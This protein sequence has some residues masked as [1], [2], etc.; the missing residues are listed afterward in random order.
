[1]DKD[2]KKILKTISRASFPNLLLGDAV[3]SFREEQENGQE[4][5]RRENKNSNLESLGTTASF[6]G[7]VAGAVLAASTVYNYEKVSEPIIDSVNDNHSIVT[8]TYRKKD[9]M[10][11]DTLGIGVPVL[12][13]IDGIASKLVRGYEEPFQKQEHR[14][15]LDNVNL[16]TELNFTYDGKPISQEGHAIESPTIGYENITC[17][18]TVDEQ[19]KPTNTKVLQGDK[20]TTALEDLPEITNPKTIRPLGLICEDIVREHYKN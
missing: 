17:Q 7:Y 4:Y 20:N 13:I 1:M 5:C 6:L 10:L 12:G 9:T 18:V 3:R 16:K 19:G 8:T 11:P 15:T 2:L 14:I